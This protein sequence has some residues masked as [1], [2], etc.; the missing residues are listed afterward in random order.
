MR[1]CLLFLNRKNF[2]EVTTLLSTAYS[3]H[4]NLPCLAGESRLLK[5]ASFLILDYKLTCNSLPR[6]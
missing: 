4:C 2:K 1:K 6:F 3:G 5:L